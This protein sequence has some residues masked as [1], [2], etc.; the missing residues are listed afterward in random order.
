MFSLLLTNNCRKLF[1]S[2]FQVNVDTDVSMKDVIVKTSS[3]KNI[4]HQ[5]YLV[6]VI[7]GVS[8]LTLSGLGYLRRF[9]L[10]TI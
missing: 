10:N 7:L 5:H 3:V 2:H 8:T 1:Q 6:L 9:Y 4:L